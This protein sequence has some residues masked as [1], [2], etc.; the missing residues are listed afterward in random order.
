[1]LPVMKVSLMKYLRFVPEP[2]D[3]KPAGSGQER[4]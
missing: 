4:R 3:T 1:M 2:K